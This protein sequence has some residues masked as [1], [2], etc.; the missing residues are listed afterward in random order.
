MKKQQGI[1]LVIT[2]VFVSFLLGLFLGRTQ[3]GSEIRVSV[4]GTMQTV[5]PK[6]TIPTTPTS[7]VSFPININT[8]TKEELMLLPGVGDVLAQR[9]LDYR[10]AFLLFSAPEELMNVEGIGKKQLEEMLHLI[11]TGG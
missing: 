10:R 4:S 7:D 8:A 9:I 2:L 6:I 3:S 1:M 11:T 5:P